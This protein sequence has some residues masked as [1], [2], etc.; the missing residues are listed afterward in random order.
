MSLPASDSNE[1]RP[2]SSTPVPPPQ[3]FDL[4]A[5]WIQHQ[6]LIIRIVIVAL[7]AVAVWGAFLFMDYRR[8]ASSEE[9]LAN[10]KTA[11]DYG[12][13]AADWPGTAAAG[14][15]TVRLAEELRKEGKP[16][17]AAKALREFVEKYPMHPLRVSAAH[18]LAASL[19]TAGKNEEALTAYQ[20]FGAAHG[21]SAF[22]PLAS[23]GQARVLVALNRTEEA[24]KVLESVE[25]KF[26][27]NPFVYD[28]RTL[29]EEIK[30][31][32]GR[33]TGGSPRPTPVPA[34]TP[35]PA[36]A[37]N[38]QGGTPPP[39]TP[40][41]PAPAISLTPAPAPAPAAPAAPHASPV[42]PAT[43]PSPPPATPATP[44]AEPPK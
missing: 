12:K 36:P 33:K 41:A 37:I 23:I 8:R 17:E 29:L 43:P 35:A 38:L 11:A 3:E 21:R 2:A 39:A 30:N 16:A 40:G 6:R 25:Q 20:Q 22:A 31:A 34:P 5:F 1:P 9:S 42:K 13:T 10:A 7:L 14:T 4:L 18:A 44:P 28:A 24:Q 32:A 19:E 26:P 15:A 27:G